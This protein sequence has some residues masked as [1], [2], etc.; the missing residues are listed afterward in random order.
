VKGQFPYIAFLTYNYNGPNG[1]TSQQATG[2]I[3]SATSVITTA[4]VFN[5]FPAGGAELTVEVGAFDTKQPIQ[6]FSFPATVGTYVL[7]VNGS[8]PPTPPTNLI[9]I[10]SLFVKGASAY[11][12]AIVRLP[13][14]AGNTFDF[15]NNEIAIANFPTS[16]AI[17]SESLYA[18][19]YGNQAP[20]VG[21]FPVL[22]FTQMFLKKSN[23]CKG[24]LTAAGVA[25]LFNANQHFCVQSKDISKTNGTFEGVCKLDIGG[26]LVRTDDAT[27][28]TTYYEVLGLIS[29]ANDTTTCNVAARTPAIVVYLF[30]FQDTFFTPILGSLTAAGNKQDKTKNPNSAKGNFI[31][32]NGKIDTSYEKC[33]PATPA[34][35]PCCNQWICAF[36]PAGK[37]CGTAAENNATKNVCL[38]KKICDNNGTCAARPRDQ[39]KKC[40]GKKT[41]CR[42][43]VCKRCTTLNSVE[44]C[45][46]A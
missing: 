32:G 36:K 23:K 13:T 1:P 28:I 15:S 45:V 12:V 33:D 40:N 17:P 42:D 3:Y 24:N 11:D 25:G 7:P 2:I 38:T 44:S 27:K 31:C 5:N 22:K 35:Q 9:V 19:A 8:T 30:W 41:Q 46:N 10:P 20:D 34:S 16:S 14:G 4:N 26:A 6:F 21:T 39:G 37:K 43:G 29:Y 18:V